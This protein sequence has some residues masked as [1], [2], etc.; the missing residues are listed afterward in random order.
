MTQKLVGILFFAAA[1]NISLPEASVAEAPQV[2]SPS[3]VIYLADNLDEKDQ[4]GWC[5]DTQGRGF[6]EVLHAHSCKPS[7]GDTQFH[8]DTNTGQIR[9]VAFANKC[10]T[11]SDPDNPTLPFGLLDCEPELSSQ[12]FSYDAQSLE[13]RVAERDSQCIVVGAASRSA[14]PF[15]SRELT[16]A[17]CADAADELK[18][19]IVKA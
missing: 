16:L 10:M 13:L 12:Q 5:I 15:M 14:G 3:P 19:W 18:Q 9:S 6:S 4:L 17:N 11:L 1:I 8:F 2:Q 7:G